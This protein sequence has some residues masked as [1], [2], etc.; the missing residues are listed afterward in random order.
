MVLNH[1]SLFSGIGGPEIAASMLHWNN[2][3][4][5][6]INP[7]GR[8][9]LE[10]WYP[11]SD[12][13][14][15]ITKTDFKQYRGNIDV[16]SGGFPCQP[17]SCA[18]R[19]KGQ[20]D[21]RYL[22]PEMLRCITECQP[23]WVCGENVTGIVTMVEQGQVS[24]VESQTSLFGENNAL[25]YKYTE[26]FTIERIISDLENIGY[27]VQPVVILAC[28]VGAPHRRDRIFIIAHNKFKPFENAMRGGCLHGQHEEPR[29]IGN[30]RDFGA[31][32]QERICRKTD[33]G[34]FADTDSDRGNEI[35]QYIQSE[36]SDGTEPFSNGRERTSAYSKSMQ[37]NGGS[38]YREHTQE[39][40]QE[41]GGSNLSADTRAVIANSF[42]N[43]NRTP[44]TSIGTPNHRWQI[45][46][47]SCEWRKPSEWNNGFP[48][49]QWIDGM[50]QA[51][52]WSQF[53]SVSPIHRGND[54]FPFDVDNLTISF[55]KWRTESLKA[56]GNAIVPQVI[57]S[58]FKSIDQYYEQE[59]K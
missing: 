40:K 1:A 43:G 42:D 32:S 38:F 59:P 30:I 34:T 11:N 3:F 25:H 47:Q 10:Y 51:N 50:L 41:S 5:C 44:E 27:E 13:Y 48:Q 36:L 14:E 56:Y 37:C 2:L 4:H 52:R 39:S 55:A 15:D 58:I 31:G 29:S 22:W 19:R 35:H 12:S 57:F 49:F 9:V 54:G 46:S 18:G 8:R 33:A 26:R 17:F 6:E 28:A 45:N 7:F 23:T 16:L 53:P 21:S 24:G 20:T